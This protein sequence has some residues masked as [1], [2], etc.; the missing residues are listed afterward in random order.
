MMAKTGLDSLELRR[1]LFDVLFLQKL[2]RNEVDSSLL[3]S[4]LNFYAPPYRTRQN[5]VFYM[6][7]SPT[8]YLINRPLSRMQRLYNR[9]ASD[10]DTLDDLLQA[11][12]GL[13]K[14]S[15]REVLRRH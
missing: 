13:F 2:I 8:N 6:R 14:R 11:P 9:V 10:V 3:L 15:V 7:S 12:T 5:Q 1:E 4:R